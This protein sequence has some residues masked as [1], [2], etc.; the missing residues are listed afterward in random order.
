MN[1]Q[2]QSYSHK[3][4]NTESSRTDISNQV[5]IMSASFFSKR[6]PNFSHV[7]EKDDGYDLAVMMAAC[8]QFAEIYDQLGGTTFA[9]LNKEITK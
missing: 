7:S 6:N 8:R 5:E 4:G 1:S 3:T 9:P 2:I